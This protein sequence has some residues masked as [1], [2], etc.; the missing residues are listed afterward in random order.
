MTVGVGGW[1]LGI[2]GVVLSF[3][4][5]AQIAAWNTDDAVVHTEMYVSIHGELHNDI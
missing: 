3:A 4:S 1:G 2:V 5:E